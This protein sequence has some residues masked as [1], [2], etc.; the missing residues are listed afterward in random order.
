MDR[1]V[2]IVSRRNNNPFPLYNPRGY[3]GILKSGVLKV[4]TGDI[5]ARFG[6][7]QY[8]TNISPDVIGGRTI[9][10]ALGSGKMSLGQLA[11][12]IYGDA[13][14]LNGIT[15]YVEIDVRGLDVTEPRP[16]TFRV[17]NTGGLDVSNRVVSSGSSC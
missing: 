17:A 16:G 1:P 10:D 3:E 11:S 6:S 14:K 7:V 9:K 13:R 8:F 2:G 4:S 5:H 12:D 15:N